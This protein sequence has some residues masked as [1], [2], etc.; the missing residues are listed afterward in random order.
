MT[1]IRSIRSNRGRQGFPGPQGVQGIQGIQGPPGGTTPI[2][3]NTLFGNNTVGPIPPIGLTVPQVKTMLGYRTLEEVDTAIDDALDD[4]IV[5]WD[6]IE[7]GA[8][9]IDRLPSVVGRKD[10]AN[11]WAETQLFQ[12]P[13]TVQDGGG[14]NVFDVTTNQIRFRSA[15]AGYLLG[16]SGQCLAGD[17]A[18]GFYY[19]MGYTTPTKPI[20]IGQSLTTQILANAQTIDNRTAE[21]NILGVDGTGWG[22][23]RAGQATFNGNV[24][25]LTRLGVGASGFGSEKVRIQDT[26]NSPLFAL[27]RN[28]DTGSS[29]TSGLVLNAY[30]N[31]WGIRMGSAANNSNALEIREDALGANT[32]RFKM[33]VGGEATFSSSFGFSNARFE[34]PTAAS[35]ALKTYETSLSAWQEPWR[36]QASASGA[37]I[38]FLGATPLVR[39]TLPA[40]A[41]DAATTQ[42][43]ANALRT[44]LINFGLAN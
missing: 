24:L 33:T 44:A 4:W 2:A 32:L 17:D 37:T 40:A 31:S 43:L 36:G 5:T 41:T 27:I 15:S 26:V 28:D 23:F 11:A 18:G 34:Q 20:Y 10:Q 39:Q 13:I 3:A 35:A 14:N 30:G 29:A 38:G 22:A 9:P 1:D 12:K 6:S 8:L 21:F 25:A 7:A 42:S 16:P 19:G